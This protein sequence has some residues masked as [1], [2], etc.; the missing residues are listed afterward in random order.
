MEVALCRAAVG[1]CLRPLRM[2]PANSAERLLG[3]FLP[4]ENSSLEIVSVLYT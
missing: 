2:N 3:A 4:C 1:F